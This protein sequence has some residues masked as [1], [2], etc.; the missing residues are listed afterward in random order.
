MKKIII[1]IIALTNLLFAGM[2]NDYAYKSGQYFVSTQSSIVDITINEKGTSEGCAKLFVE[3]GSIKTNSRYA[4]DW[5]EGCMS[6]VV[7]SGRSRRY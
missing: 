6:V 2:N 7:N 3:F 1:G 4:R 5:I